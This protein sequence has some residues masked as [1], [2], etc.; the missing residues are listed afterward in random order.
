MNRI[1][2]LLALC[3]AFV[4]A[5]ASAGTGKVIKVLPL[6]VDTNGLHSLSPSLFDR[7]AYQA[8]LRR[9]PDECAGTRF[10]IQWK[11]SGAIYGPLL[12]RVEIR[13]TAKGD[14]P[15]RTTL[16][17]KLKPGGWFSH[18]AEI[19][20]SGDAY[21]KSGTVTAWRVTLWE[22]DELLGEQKSFLW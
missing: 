19:N 11:T 4:A 14:L 16:E 18:W 22:G 15:T 2:W 7:D 6:L 9:H 20:L 10:A 1:F 13:G 5:P 12:L 8:Y 21:R 17:E 3:A